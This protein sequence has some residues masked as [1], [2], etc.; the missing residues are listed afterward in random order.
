MENYY[1]ILG[2]S[3]N[4]TQ[5]DIKKVY[6]KLAVEH[7]PDKGGDEETFKRISEAYDTL[8]NE[9][10]KAQ[11]DGQKNNPFGGFGEGNPFDMFGDFFNN[12]QSQPRQRRA[13]DKLIDVIVGVVDSYVERP[14]SVNY[15]RKTSCDSC[16]GQGGERQTCGTCGGQG[17]IIQRVGNSFFANIVRTICVTCQG[18]GYSLINKCYICNGDGRKDEFKTVD[19]KLPHGITDGQ[20]IRASQMGDYQEGIFG[21]IILK[22]KIVPQDGFEKLND[23]LIYNYQ[24]S[25]ND[26]NKDSIEVSHPKGLLNLQLPEEVDTNKPLRVK[27]KG[28]NGSD[29]YIKLFVKHKRS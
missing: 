8:G 17:H 23:D 28:F 13:P 25:L 6:R 21:D 27:G 24:M 26:F 10:K 22:I 19:F 14:M 4:A 1:K 20:F 18:K 3:E 5:D 11:Y 7:H 12:M 2:V 15:S 29:F 16:S 9:T